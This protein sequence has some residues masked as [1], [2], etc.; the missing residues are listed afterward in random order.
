MK[1]LVFEKSLS[2]RAAKL[3]SNPDTF[4]LGED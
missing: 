1:G 3:P 4:S 2:P